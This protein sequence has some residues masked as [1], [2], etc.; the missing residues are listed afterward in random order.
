[1]KRQFN[2][3]S[4]GKQVHQY[5]Q[6]KQN[7]HSPLLITGHKERQRHMTLEIQVLAWGR[8]KNVAGV[9]PAK[10]SSLDCITH[11]NKLLKTNPAEIRC[12]SKISHIIKK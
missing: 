11:M 12:H 7:H 8:N 1:M 9:K 2:S 5:Q 3:N 4:D 6:S 10:P